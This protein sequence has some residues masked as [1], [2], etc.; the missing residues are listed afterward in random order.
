MLKLNPDLRLFV[1]LFSQKFD[2][3]RINGN[4]SKSLYRYK[5]DL[6]CHCRIPNHY[7]MIN[8]YLSS[9][10]I[11]TGYFCNRQCDYRFWCQ[12]F[13]GL[14]LFIL[15]IFPFLLKESLVKIKDDTIY[16]GLVSS[17]LQHKV[18]S[19]NWNKLTENEKMDRRASTFFSVLYTCF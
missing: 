6:L 8:S 14:L 15:I 5:L 13:T 11:K 7:K 12:R 9:L 4:L 18:F 10:I 17:S 2:R 19:E 1:T 3:L 16:K